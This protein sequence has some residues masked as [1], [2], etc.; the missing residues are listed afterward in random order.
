M[1]L[2]VVAQLA[3]LT[4]VIQVFIQLLNVVVLTT[5]MGASVPPTI[6]NVMSY[7]SRMNTTSL[8]ERQQ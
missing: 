7:F 5:L 2:E 4:S 3:N 6:T 8:F 1:P